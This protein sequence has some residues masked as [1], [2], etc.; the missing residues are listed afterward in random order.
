MISPSVSHD[1]P[2]SEKSTTDRLEAAIAAFDRDMEAIRA[3]ATD[4]ARH[5]QFWRELRADAERIFAGRK[6]G[7]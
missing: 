5:E 2:D 6:G 4:P 1:N 7:A 3:E